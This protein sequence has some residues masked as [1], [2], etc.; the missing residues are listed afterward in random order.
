MSGCDFQYP[1][2][3]GYAPTPPQEFTSS[4]SY[5]NNTS[6]ALLIWITAIAG[7]GGSGGCANVSGASAGGGGSGE[8]CWR[9]PWVL[10]VA[11]T[12]TITIGAAGTAGASGDNDGGTGGD[13]IIT[14]GS[15]T[16][17]LKG[18]LFGARGSIKTG[19]N[20]G[21]WAAPAPGSDSVAE[22]YWTRSG[23]PGGTAGSGAQAGGFESYRVGNSTGSGNGGSSPFG[24]GGAGSASTQA[25][26]S[27]AATAY[28]AGASGAHRLVVNPS[29]NPGAAGAPGFVRLEFS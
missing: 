9:M 25:G 10:A 14:D 5:T 19:G 8:N 17:T 18:G 26:V 29:A 24:L 4:G 13:T 6:A 16:V 21:G 12:L 7:G 3:P 20:G 2:A 11:A 28:G 22:G 1:A 27:P 15:R 23:A